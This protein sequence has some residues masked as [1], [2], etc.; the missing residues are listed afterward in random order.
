M[1]EWACGVLNKYWAVLNPLSE[2]LPFSGSNTENP[3]TKPTKNNQTPKDGCGSAKISHDC[4]SKLSGFPF[5]KEPV[6]IPPPIPCL[7]FHFFTRGSSTARVLGDVL[8]RFRSPARARTSAERY[9]KPYSGGAPR[10]PR[11]ERKP[12]RQKLGVG[13][14]Q[15]TPPFAEIARK[16]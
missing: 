15:P 3:T 1:L 7:R 12:S 14:T 9:R 11:Q 8:F 5:E 10:R 6:V 16:K 13:S 4:R 2:R